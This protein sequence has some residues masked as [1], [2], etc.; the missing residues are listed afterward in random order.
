MYNT[1]KEYYAHAKLELPDNPQWHQFKIECANGKFWVIRDSI[2]TVETLR[3]WLLRLTPINVYSSA[4]CFLAPQELSYAEFNG[5]RAGYNHSQNIIIGDGVLVF[6]VD[7][8][9][10]RSFQDAK[11]DALAIMDCLHEKGYRVDE[12]VFSGAGFRLIVN[13]HGLHL[14]RTY[15]RRNNKAVFQK[16]RELR[17]PIINELKQRGIQVD[18]ETTLDIRR[19]IRLVGTPNSKNGY[20]C[21]SIRDLD[22][23]ELADVERLNLGGVAPAT[24]KSGMTEFLLQE[25]DA[26]DSLWGKSGRTRRTGAKPNEVNPTQSA[27]Q[28]C[29]YLGSPAIRTLD[30]QIVMLRFKSD[31]NVP[32]LTK[33]LSRFA[34]QEKLAPFLIFRSVKDADGLWALSPTA[35]QTGGLPRL[36]KR[37]P[38]D[39]ATY[40]L[41][42][43]TI[44]DGA[45]IPLKEMGRGCT[46]S[47][48][49]GRVQVNGSFSRPYHGILLRVEGKGLLPFDVTP[50]HPILVS[51]LISRYESHI[52]KG[53]KLI[54]RQKSPKGRVL[55][56]KN[57][58]WIN[59]EALS[60]IRERTAAQSYDGHYLV[61]SR[62][63]GKCKMRF[64]SL[65]PFFSDKGMFGRKERPRNAKTRF[66]LT[67]DTAWLLG[68][69]V[70]EGSSDHATRVVLAMGKRNMKLHRRIKAIVS[71][72][73][74]S[75][76]RGYSHSTIDAII[77]S[78]LLAK[79]F[80]SWCG[81]GA[82]HKHVPAFILNHNDDG[83][84]RAF[85]DGYLTGDGSIGKRGKKAGRGIVVRATTSS[86]ILALQLQLLVARLGM[87]APVFRNRPRRWRFCFG[88]LRLIQTSYTVQFPLVRRKHSSRV[89]KKII[90]VPIDKIRHI[91]YSGS[92]HNISTNDATFSVSNV[93]VH[94]C[95]FHRRIVPLP[96]EYVAQSSG[97]TDSE[98]PVSRAHL[99]Y[100]QHYNLLP[101]FSPRISC[102]SPTLLST[103]IGEMYG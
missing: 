2:R 64:V 32:E 12:I 33:T 82:T 98:I 44:I 51:N 81:N 15:S 77:G 34:A 93:I 90:L 7:F 52:P 79:A 23:F 47:G 17:E 3:D 26:D 69:Y 61:M 49:S 8:H 91:Q 42:P 53:I 18:S 5:K 89:F 35:V 59:A 37:F 40:C 74:Y 100:F 57:P 88:K 39:R 96:I 75:V 1:L 83:I 60:C 94:N 71:S 103:P 70:A 45:Y 62:Q 101:S 76:C 11:R 31:V 30:R 85:L 102:G 65:L 50:E 92:V 13:N 10:E 54:I 78:R 48:L 63:K 25:K 9:D 72:I 21:T 56:Y 55:S 24:T 66:P 19:V 68:F 84:L 20:V 38:S 14:P 73:G 27:P 46:C 43:S 95:K 87:W 80:P 99:K 4:N 58:Y 16:Y 41:R 28:P 22:G 29:I 36:L 86:K 97:V 6:D 67:Y